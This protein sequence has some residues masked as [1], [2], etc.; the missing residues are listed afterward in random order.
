M[1]NLPF[2]LLRQDIVHNSV[3]GFKI[4]NATSVIDTGQENAVFR[5]HF[6]RESDIKELNK[7][8]ISVICLKVGSIT[9]ACR[10]ADK[11]LFTLPATAMCWFY[12]TKFPMS[13]H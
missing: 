1:I 10:T 13:M 3:R 9:Q 12:H 11:Q 4:D 7:S 6:I 2:S 5:K 8:L